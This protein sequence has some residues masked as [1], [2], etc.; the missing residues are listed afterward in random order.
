MGGAIAKRL[1]EGGFPVSVWDRTRTKAEATGAGVVAGSPVEA[2]GQA[3]VVI[4]MVTGPQAVRDIYLGSG[5]VLKAGAGKTIVEMSTAGP[6]VALELAQAAAG[7]GVTLVQAPVIG[8]TPAVANGTLVSLA[9]ADRLDD[10][11]PALPVLEHLGEVHYVGELATAASLKLVANSFL[12]IISAAAAE[13]MA[14]GARAGL[15]PDQVFAILTRAA[16]GLKVREAGFVRH[17]HQPAMFNTR[18]IVKDLDLGLRLYVQ[19]NASTGTV[20]VT[21]VVRDLFARVAEVAPD[22]DITAITNAYSPVPQREDRLR[23]RQAAG[24]SR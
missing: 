15:D 19:D 5:G 24:S 20:P 1:S 22:L 6:E 11:D 18:D 23:S 12:A 9:S 4:S 2:A 14:A 13:L 16:P 17:Q 3:D 7:L 10:L 8:S 21:A